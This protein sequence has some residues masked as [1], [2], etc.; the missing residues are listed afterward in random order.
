VDAVVATTAPRSSPPAIRGDADLAAVGSVLADRARCRI[1]LALADGRALPASMLAA[2]AGVA[3][4]TASSHLARLVDANL[5]TVTAH[6][7]YRYYELAG[8]HV[9][10]LIE[11][12]SRL[13]PAEEVRSLT[14]GTR[15][16]AMRR[17]RTCYDHLAGRFGVAVT[18]GLID[19]GALRA[20]PTAD[21]GPRVAHG[22]AAGATDQ[23][24]Y[25]V[26]PAG[27]R[28]FADIGVEVDPGTW[29]RCC[30]DWTEQRHHMAG[31]PGRAVLARFIELDWVRPAPRGR[32][33]TVTEGGLAGLADWIGFDPAVLDDRPIG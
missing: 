33:V 11:M 9:G 10:E 17:A 13:A 28:R 14:Q 24:G 4:S 2:E 16:H 12:V 19:C 20:L 3:A 23:A 7:R 6:G 26:E 5:V 18:A 30:V 31:G 27:R 32:A 15:A 22:S 29:V 1:L 8:S 25:V 21:D